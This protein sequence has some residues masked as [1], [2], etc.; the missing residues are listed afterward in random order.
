MGKIKFKNL[1][2]WRKTINNK[3]LVVI[4][5]SFDILHIGHIKMLEYAKSL[6]DILL[7][8]INSD[9]SIKKNKGKDRPINNEKDRAK[10]LLSLKSVDFVCVFNDKTAKNLLRLSKPNIHVKG[11]DYNLDNMNQEEKGMLESIDC[12]IVFYKYIKGKST[13]NIIKILEKV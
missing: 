8:G 6:G 4:N 13:T 9:K 7:V 2:K 12:K 3:T 11:G 5:G 10:F 1:K